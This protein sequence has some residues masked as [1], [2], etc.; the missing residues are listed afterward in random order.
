MKILA[1]GAHPD[2]IEI[3]MFGLLSMCAQRGDDIGL[4]VATD[5]AA[6]S[7]LLNDNLKK[8]RMEETIQ[9]LTKLGRP[10]FLGFS[11]GNLSSDKDAI[12]VLSKTINFHKPDLI[13]THAPEDYHPDHRALSYFV[14]QATGFIC[15]VIFC[16]TLMGINFEPE[17]YIDISSVFYLKQEAILAHKSQSPKKFLNAAS[18][19]NRYRSA[20]CNDAEDNFAEAYR[21][22]KS[23]PFSDVRSL[24][25][26][27]P[28]INQFYKNKETSFI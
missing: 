3:F 18:L 17:I 25:P 15:P 12:N 26:L 5:G 28:K 6:G 7:V 10:E 2:D 21:H 8:I 19:M 14:T 16:D 11:D 4:I 9:A 22:Q 24:L 13:I 20:Q 27:A 23:F 1:I